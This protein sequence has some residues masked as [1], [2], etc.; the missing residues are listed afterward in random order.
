MD[1]I[2]VLKQDHRR[3]EELFSKFLE[4][5]SELTQEDLFQQ[6]QTELT[7]HAEAE[8]RVFYP[9]I[10]EHG[11]GAI[12][13]ALQDHARVKELLMEILTADL[14]EDGFESRFT[15]LMQDVRSHVEEE[16]GPGGIME[17]A[18]QNL[19]DVTLRRM[20]EDIRTVKE[21]IEDDMAA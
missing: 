2:D 1:A 4:T 9:A 3:V 8:E 18:R 5:D 11:S 13:Q 6:I 7:A 19:D 21:S 12:E 16:E 20:V 17:M 10:R 15:E 14:D